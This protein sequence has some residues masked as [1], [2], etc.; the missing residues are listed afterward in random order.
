MPSLW[1][2]ISPDWDDLFKNM[3][4][5]VNAEVDIRSSGFMEKP[6]YMGE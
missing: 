3:D 1:K 5:S 4:V 6:I 2:S